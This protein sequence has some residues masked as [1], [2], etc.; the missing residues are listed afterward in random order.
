MEFFWKGYGLQCKNQI[1]EGR[2]HYQIL[3]TSCYKEAELVKSEIFSCTFFEK[4]NPWMRR[5]IILVQKYINKIWADAWNER[6]SFLG[7]P[8]PSHQH[9]LFCNPGIGWRTRP[10]DFHWPIENIVGELFR[11]T[12]QDSKL[13]NFRDIILRG[14][15]IGSYIR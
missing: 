11:K 10:S 4:K 12:L 14:K 5:S 7:K 13:L 3:I 2:L 15:Y 9:T 1:F 8:I 6:A